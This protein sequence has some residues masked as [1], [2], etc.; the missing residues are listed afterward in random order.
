MTA[1]YGFTTLHG[2]E[3]ESHVT[4]KLGQISTRWWLRLLSTIM[5]QPTY[6]NYK[7]KKCIL[8]HT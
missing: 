3:V 4:Q 8:G 1:V 6:E 5:P 7:A 2:S